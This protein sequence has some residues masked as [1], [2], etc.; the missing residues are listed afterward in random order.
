MTNERVPDRDRLAAMIAVEP[1]IIA[2]AL[3]AE[4]ASIASILTHE[5]AAIAGAVIKVSKASGSAAEIDSPEDL[6]SVLAADFQRRQ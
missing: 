6:A 3:A 2:Q 1:A 5:P 4:P